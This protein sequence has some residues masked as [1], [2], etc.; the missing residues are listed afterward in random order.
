MTLEEALPLIVKAAE[1]AW[2]IICTICGSA[3]LLLLYIWRQ[4]S[5][6]TDTLIAVTSDMGKELH[7]MSD[8]VEGLNDTV[9]KQWKMISKHETE[10]AVIN[11]KLRSNGQS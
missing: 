3:V 4:R 2:W 11:E 7:T 1:A 9:T 5:K 6:Q 8:N 10:L